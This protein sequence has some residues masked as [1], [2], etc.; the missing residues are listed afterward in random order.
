MPQ[1]TDTAVVSVETFASGL[2]SRLLA[3]RELHHLW[4]PFTVEVIHTGAGKRQRIGGYVRVMRCRQCKTLRRQILDSRG[5]IVGN[6]YQYVDGYLASN[7]ER[8]SVRRDVFRLES[9][10]RFVESHRDDGAVIHSD[11]GKSPALVPAQREG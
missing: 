10:I 1:Q 11:N 9:I 6:S 8:G 7:V 3:C 5:G 4:V 2:N